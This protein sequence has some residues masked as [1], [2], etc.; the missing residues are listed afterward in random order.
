M[1]VTV[2]FPAVAT[3]Q[4]ADNPTH[5]VVSLAATQVSSTKFTTF[6][7]AHP[8]LAPQVFVTHFTP[9]SLLQLA[10]SSYTKLQMRPLSKN[11]YSPLS[12]THNSST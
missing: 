6:K 2:P 3:R 9:A 7:F 12:T 5:S 11:I 4:D 8:L 1:Y 10:L